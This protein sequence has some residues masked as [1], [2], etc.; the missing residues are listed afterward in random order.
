M[1]M[2]K[3]WKKK[4][5]CS[6][7]KDEFWKSWTI[8]ANH[9]I[10]NDNLNTI[11]VKTLSIRGSTGLSKDFD[12]FL[13][14]LSSYNR[15]YEESRNKSWNIVQDDILISIEHIPPI[16]STV[17]F[18]KI[19]FIPNQE[20]VT[21]N[22]E[23]FLIHNEKLKY[24]LCKSEYAYSIFKSFKRKHKCKWEVIKFTFPPVVNKTYF[25]YAKD[26]NIVLHAAGRSWMKNT[27]IIIETWRKHPEWPI[28]AISCSGLC[29]KHHKLGHDAPN[30]LIY[31]FF[32]PSQMV[33]FQKHAG[34]CI[35]PSACEGF[36]HSLYEAMA[37]GNLL[38]SGDI[39]PVNEHINKNNAVLI[40]YHKIHKLGGDKE[41][42][43][44][45]VN[46][47]SEIGEAGSSCFEYTKS[48]IEY[49]VEVAINLSD[50]EYALKRKNAL[51]TWKHLMKD[52]L[53]STEEALTITGLRTGLNNCWYPAI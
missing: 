14:I 3:R 51:Q 25:S 9:C 39:P 38:I 19:V 28:L 37:N 13:Y 4:T 10:I 2:T 53:V 16:I 18:Q 41:H 44:P 33:E 27:S 15:I 26:R 24:I 30:I 7:L 12:V 46:F 20:L 48:D 17:E 35:F 32:S 36:G 50:Y 42:F 22:D 6:S 29:K 8:P 49:A 40:N 45:F 43:I 52:G 34:Y 21:K 31:D 5:D 23:F 11:P 1:F 47:S